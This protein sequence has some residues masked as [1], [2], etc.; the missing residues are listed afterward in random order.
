M[1]F[2]CAPPGRDALDDEEAFAGPDV[3][4]ATSLA[5]QGLGRVAFGKP[6]LET[7]L[8][9][10][11]RMHLLSAFGQSVA[12]GEVAAQRL[13]VEE[14]DEGDDRDRQPAQ[15]E[16]ATRQPVASTTLRTATGQLE[17]VVRPRAGGS[18]S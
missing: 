4:E 11:E 18:L 17:Q 10:A 6:T 14:G 3:A 7:Q 16:P 5:S 15:E 2:V 13:R 12:G 9:R 8:L 1:L